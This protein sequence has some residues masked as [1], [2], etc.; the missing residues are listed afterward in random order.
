[1]AIEE[2]QEDADVIQGW[3]DKWYVLALPAICIFFRIF[4]RHE[5]AEGRRRSPNPAEQV[6][7]LCTTYLRSMN[8]CAPG[9]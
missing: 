3:I 9:G 4:E 7:I 6:E 8:L 1:M 5:A 2:S